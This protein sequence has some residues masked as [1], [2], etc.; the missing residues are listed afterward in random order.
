MEVASAAASGQ[1]A[2]TLLP[3][4]CT[5]SSTTFEGD[6]GLFTRAKRTFDLMIWLR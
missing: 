2:P 1:I 5:S 4:Q 6:F 3:C